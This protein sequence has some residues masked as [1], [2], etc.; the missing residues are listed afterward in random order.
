MRVLLLAW[1]RARSILGLR[2]NLLG[3]GLCFLHF[4][5]IFGLGRWLLPFILVLAFFSLSR[6][7]LVTS[8]LGSL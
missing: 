5:G 6:L 8:L 3:F 2:I 4:G 1:L 7:A